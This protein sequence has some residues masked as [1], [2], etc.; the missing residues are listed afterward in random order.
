M[1][2]PQ[3]SDERYVQEVMTETMPRTANGAAEPDTLADLYQLIRTKQLP[4]DLR[5]DAIA[6][7][8]R[9]GI[10]ANGTEEKGLYMALFRGR[11]DHSGADLIA[12]LYEDTDVQVKDIA[13]AMSVDHNE[14]ARVRRRRKLATREDRVPFRPSA[15]IGDNEELVIINGEAVFR[16]L[17]FG[18]VRPVW[19]E[20]PKPPQPEPQPEPTPEPAPPQPEP[21]PVPVASLEEQ[22]KTAGRSR[23]T[24][25]T[26]AELTEIMAMYQDESI[27]LS[28][29]CTAYNTNTKSIYG[30]AHRMGIKGRRRGRK[31]HVNVDMSGHYVMVDGHETW[32]PG[33]PTENQQ[34]HLAQAPGAQLATL[35]PVPHPPV[36]I[37]ERAWAITHV[38]TVVTM[39]NAASIDEALRQLRLQYGQ[40]VDVVTVQRA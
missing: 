17:A 6:R 39:V 18:T 20:E 38:A 23:R 5:E 29:I 30:I 11:E 21:E 28:E 33:P 40:E 10:P 9:E 37:N 13:R 1:K 36:A 24:P 4:S 32:V 27:P 25:F 15:R 3:L 26:S 8:R 2:S 7:I 19:P 34:L 14:I 22:R 12:R 35:P 31:P 16:D